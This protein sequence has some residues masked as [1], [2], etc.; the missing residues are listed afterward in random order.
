MANEKA[1][2]DLQILTWFMG[3]LIHGLTAAYFSG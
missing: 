3:G 2:E 1:I